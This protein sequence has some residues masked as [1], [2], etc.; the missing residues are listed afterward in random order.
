LEGGIVSRADEM[1]CVRGVNIY[2]TAI[3]AVIR[4]V[5][6]VAEYRATVRSNGALGTVAVEVEVS[7]SNRDAVTALVE[8]RLRE[9]LGLT[10][11]VNAVEPG[12]LPRYE[13]KAK[14]FIVEKGES[15][16]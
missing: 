1:V 13:M 4:T 15:T 9:A 12:A 14:R 10:V 2:P 16:E 6:D 5:R 11:A 7:S 8:S 3:E